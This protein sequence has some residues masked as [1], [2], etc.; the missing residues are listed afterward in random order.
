MIRC[1]IRG[2]IDVLRVL[3]L[4]SNSTSNASWYLRLQFDRPVDLQINNF[5]TYRWYEMSRRV[6]PINDHPRL[7]RFRPIRMPAARSPAAPGSGTACDE[8]VEL[9]GAYG[10]L[11]SLTLMF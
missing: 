10:L 2:T 6:R 3:G 9:S 5:E 11:G 7:L 8:P 4:Q 1:T